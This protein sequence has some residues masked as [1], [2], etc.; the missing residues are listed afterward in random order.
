MRAVRFHEFG[1]PSVLRV[2][3]APDPEVEDDAVLV[4]VAAAG[5]NPIDAEIRGGRVS[6]VLTGTPP[7]GLGAEIAGTVER[8]GPLAR[9]F[10][11]GDRVIAMLPTF[12]G[13]G[14]SELVAV[15]EDDVAPWPGDLPAPE[16][17]AMPLAALT[18]LQALRAKGGLRAKHRVL[19]N[20]ASGG[21]GSMAVQLAALLG[22]HVVGTSSGAHLD[23]VRGL[24]AD[25][26]VDYRVENVTYRDGFDL[27][28]DVAGTI[29]FGLARPMLRSAG[30][31]V[32]TQVSPG[33]VTRTVLQK[34]MP[35]PTMAYCQAQPDGPALEWLSTLFAS[36][37]ARVVMD[38][39][40]AMDEAEQAHRHLEGV[41]GPGKSATRIGDAA[42][43][44]RRGGPDGRSLWRQRLG[45]SAPVGLRASL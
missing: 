16:A 12:K 10:R 13:E 34:A 5:L 20:G 39:T 44:Q 37:A 6:G 36:G 35:G 23:L 19:I 42:G 28:F 27:I 7:R 38:R 32:T 41:H 29:P 3:E 45:R 31:Y 14:Y 21:V 9:R 18:A 15:P 22:A 26:A 25:E 43:P 2:E 30:A 40:F 33:V 1:P 11:T 8:A 24:G 17:A 4:R